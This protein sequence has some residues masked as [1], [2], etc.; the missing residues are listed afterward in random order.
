MV[1]AD[2]FSEGPGTQST[3]GLQIDAVFDEPHG[4]VGERE[5]GSS[6][7]EAMESKLPEGLA[8]LDVDPIRRVDY[9]AKATIE[10]GP[11]SVG[12]GI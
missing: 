8:G 6:G 10:N 11:S 2:D 9:C 5:I 1:G 4:A 3:V 12:R 7:M